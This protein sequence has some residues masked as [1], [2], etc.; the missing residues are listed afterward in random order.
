MPAATAGCLVV[1]CRS[2]SQN[3]SKRSAQACQH[4]PG[5]R[6]NTCKGHRQSTSAQRIQH[7]RPYKRHTLRRTHMHAGFTTDAKSKYRQTAP[8]LTQLASVCKQFKPRQHTPPAESANPPQPPVPAEPLCIGPAKT[9]TQLSICGCNS[10]SLC[11]AMLA[12]LLVLCPA[13]AG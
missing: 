6:L 5:V 2:R 4:R 1:L 12:L 7:S 9:N 10:H 13:Y 11:S 8:L 3:I